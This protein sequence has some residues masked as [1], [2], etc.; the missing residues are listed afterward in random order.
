MAKKRRYGPP[1][2]LSEELTLDLTL[3]VTGTGSY[4]Y[5]NS[6]VAYATV[7][8]GYYSYGDFCI[9]VSQL[10][11]QWLFDVANHASSAIVPI[12]TVESIVFT[13]DHVDS[14]LFNGSRTNFTL[15]DPSVT[16]GGTKAAITSLSLLTGWPHLLGLA[17][18]G[19]NASGVVTAPFGAIVSGVFCPRAINCT[20]R[21]EVRLP[22]N[23]KTE[24]YQAM[25]LSDGTIE[26]Y[27][28]GNNRSEQ[29]WTI[30]DNAYPISGDPFP[31]GTLESISGSRL[32]IFC[33]Y[34]KV[35]GRVTGFTGSGLNTA[36]LPVGAYLGVDGAGA[37]GFVSRVKEIITPGSEGGL[38]RLE[39]VLWEKIP[40]SF[41]VKTKSPLYRVPEAFSAR[42]DAR[43]LDCFVLYGANESTVDTWIW[44]DWLLDQDGASFSES[45]ERRD[46]S[47][48]QFS[49]EFKGLRRVKSKLTLVT[50]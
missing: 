31:C 28:I 48:N 19:A 44:E 14:I 10:I 17:Q 40:A 25:Q 22:T 18:E 34:P 47:N 12:G 5:D 6:L 20:I 49:I 37:E 15:T 35:T 43:R 3:Q 38:N 26:S 13:I 27:Q 7:P 39:I 32:S 2:Y 33:A 24:I 45:V 36:F 1:I 9:L 21:S 8:A 4:T 46:L 11:R 50:S 16:M 30:K 42:F 29:S 41:S 23:K